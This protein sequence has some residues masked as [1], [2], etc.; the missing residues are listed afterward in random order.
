[1]GWPLTSKEYAAPGSTAAKTIS[2]LWVS[3]GLDY[4]IRVSTNARACL[5]FKQHP[6]V[7]GL[8]AGGKMIR[9]GEKSLPYGGWWSIPRVAGNG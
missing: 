5:V 3:Y 2:S 7:A 1:M 9:Y 4:R 8:L 6:L